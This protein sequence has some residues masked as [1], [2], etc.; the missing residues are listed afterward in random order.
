MGS[1]YYSNASQ[2]SRNFNWDPELAKS[3]AKRK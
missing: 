3:V 1:K 2:A